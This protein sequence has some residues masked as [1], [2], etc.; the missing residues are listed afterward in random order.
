M[1]QVNECM[2]ENDEVELYRL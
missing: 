2:I 1:K